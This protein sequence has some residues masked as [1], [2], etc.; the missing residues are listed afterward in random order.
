MPTIILVRVLMGLSFYDK[1]S[2]EEL[3]LRFVSNDGSISRLEWRVNDFEGSEDIQA[4]GSNC[5]N[6]QSNQVT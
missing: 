5:S 1:R 2:F 4:M 3:S 6:I